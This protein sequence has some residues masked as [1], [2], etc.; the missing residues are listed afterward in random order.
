MG[1]YRTLLHTPECDQSEGRVANETRRGLGAFTHRRGRVPAVNGNRSSIAGMKTL[2]P[3]PLLLLRHACFSRLPDRPSRHATPGR[4]S[5]NRGAE[6]MSFDIRW[7]LRGD[8]ESSPVMYECTH[9]S[10]ITAFRL[11]AC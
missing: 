9:Y 7:W 4:V 3:H 5:P 8:E 6:A 11:D 1:L 2:A 10:Q